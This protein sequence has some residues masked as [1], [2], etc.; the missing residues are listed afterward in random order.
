[1]QPSDEQISL[2]REAVAEAVRG[3]LRGAN[4]IDGPTHIQHHQAIAEFLALTRH[5]KKTV[6][7]GFMLG[8]MALL[9]LGLAAW[10]A[11]KSA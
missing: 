8:L 6:I 7:G 10:V 5:A 1:M 9:L 4:L 3:E 11:G 2:I